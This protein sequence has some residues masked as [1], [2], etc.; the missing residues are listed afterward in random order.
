MAQIYKFSA[1]QTEYQQARRQLVEL[2][3]AGGPIHEQAEQL[4]I[5]LDIHFNNL[6]HRIES[7]VSFDHSL[8]APLPPPID[9]K[10]LRGM[11]AYR[12]WRLEAQ[13]LLCPTVVSGDDWRSEVAF[14]DE[15]PSRYNFHGLHAT[16]LEMWKSNR[17][18]PFFF[19]LIDCYGEVVEH[20]DGV[21][22][23][24]CV[25]ILAILINVAAENDML[26][27]LTGAYEMIKNRYPNTPVYILTPY[28]LEL[29]MWREVLITYGAV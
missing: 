24:E 25:R 8:A 10:H 20:E 6:Q 3:K 15:P 2:L 28:Q 16:R 13:G 21:V 1:I 27:L 23:A 22:R 5:N 17:Y 11:L 9:R 19:G 18:S 14:A 12:T 29:Y 7:A 4:I 26:L